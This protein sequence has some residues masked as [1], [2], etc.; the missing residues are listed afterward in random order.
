[1]L[2]SA[3]SETEKQKIEQ[4]MEGDSLLSGYL[5]SLRETDKEDIVTEERSRRQAERQSRVEA[6]L[7]AMDT[8]EGGVG[9]YNRVWHFYANVIQ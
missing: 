8:E 5:R 6:D 4:T 7:E 2:A 9:S 3:Q 1:M